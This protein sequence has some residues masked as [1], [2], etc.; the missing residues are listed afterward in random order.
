MRVRRTAAP[1]A[2]VVVASLLV[3]VSGSAPASGLPGTCERTWVTN[4]G[5]TNWENSGNWT[6]AGVPSV[7]EVIC[8][9]TTEDVLIDAAGQGDFHVDEVHLEGTT[10]LDI[11]QGAGLYVDGAAESV[12]APGT[13]VTATMSQLG[14][15]G[16]IRVQGAVTFA[17][18]EFGTFLTSVQ[19]GAAVPP[20]ADTRPA[21]GR[22]PRDA[23]NLGLGALPGYHVTIASGGL[24]DA[25]PERVLR[26][27]LRHRPD[28]PPR[29][30]RRA[31][32]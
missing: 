22:G 19:D 21:D 1:A 7:G 32:R 29:W 11:G 28:H 12:W 31:G 10:T 24:V 14:G 17:S 25:G 16:T 4:G 5:D 27:R 6:P 9:S 2:L 13:S 23:G 15:S 26:R 8:I 3:A 30:H 20:P 18:G